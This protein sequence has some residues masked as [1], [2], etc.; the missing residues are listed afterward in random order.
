MARPKV[1]RRNEPPWN[2]RAREL[3]LAEKETEMT[4]QRKYTKEARAKWEIPIGPTS[5]L[6]RHKLYNAADVFLVAHDIDR[7]E[8]TKIGADARATEIMK[9]IMIALQETL[10]YS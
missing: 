6:W 1:A 5:P 7:M 2:I 4:R 9:L 10:F 8:A 3:K